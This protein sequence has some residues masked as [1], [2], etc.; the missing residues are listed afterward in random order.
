MYKNIA[1]DSIEEILFVDF[2][3][4]VETSKSCSDQNISIL[5]PNIL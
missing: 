4:Y 1:R 5:I 3:P 2:K